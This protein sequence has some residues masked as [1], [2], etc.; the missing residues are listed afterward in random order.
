MKW[1]RFYAEAL[2]D[3]KIL[4]LKDTEFRGWILILCAVCDRNGELAQ[5]DLP[6]ILRRTLIKCHALV[7][8]LLTKG[9]LETTRSGFI[10]AH[11][12][13]GRQF[14]S[15]V[16]TERVKR[17]RNAQRN[18]S[19]TPP[20]TDTDTDTEQNRSET[21]V[22][23]EQDKN[24]LPLHRAFERSFGRVLSPMEIEQIDALDEE[25]PRERIDYAL[26]EASALN[27]R[28]VRYVQRVCE[29]QKEGSDDQSGRT[30]RGGPAKGSNTESLASRVR[31]M[32]EQESRV[33]SGG[34]SRS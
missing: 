17:F 18:V 2:N 5:D 24:V 21:E 31:H 1:F 23:P 26:R 29:N 33:I 15:D 14:H 27:K 7:E 6:L 25:H 3:P 28:S 30:D 9:L 20:D 4:R 12:W 32:V 16:S 13:E 22:E 34:P 10:T 19:E 11:N 8:S